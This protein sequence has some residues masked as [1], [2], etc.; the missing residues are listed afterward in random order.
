MHSREGLETEYM[1]TEWMHCIKETVKAA[2]K[3]GMSAWL[4]DEDRFPSGGAGGMVSAAGGDVCRA[5][6][7]TLEISRGGFVNDDRV[8]TV[9]RAVICDELILE[10]KRIKE[11][12]NT[13]L[14]ENEVLLVFRMETS[15]PCEWFNNEAPANNLNPDAVAVFIKTT[16]EAYKSEI[17]E[18]FGKTVP[19]IFTDE[20]NISDGRCNFDIAKAWIPWTDEFEKYF[21]NV[22]GYDLLDVV[23]FIFF[24]AV[25]S[26]KVRHDYW[27]TV[28]E[29]YCEAYSKQIGEWCGKNNLKFTG[30]YHS[31]N[32]LGFGVRTSGAFMPHYRYLHIPGIDMLREQTAEYLTVKQCTSVANQY[33]KKYVISEMYGCTG[34]D[35]TFEGQKWMGDWQYVMGVNIRCQHLALYSLKGCRKRDYPPAFS[36]NTS[37]WKYNNVVEDYFG[38]LTAVL[39]EGKVERDVLVIHPASTAWSMVG[40]YPYEN[41]ESKDR[42]INEANE[43]G[44]RFTNFISLILGFHYDFDLGD[45][46]IL[47]EKGRVEGKKLF[48]N[49]AD[50]SLVI[51]PS[52]KTLLSSTV[53]LLRQ[54]M[55]AGG[56]AVAVAPLATMIDGEVSPEINNLFIHNNMS[57][58]N[59]QEQLCP[60]FEKLLPRRVSIRNK[61][62]TEAP[63][64]LYML[65]DL[66]DCK[67]LFV[68][69]N[70]RNN[71]HEVKITVDGEGSVEEWD[72]L[73]GKVKNIAISPKERKVSFIT[74]FGP[75]GSRLF[76]IHK[77][78]QPVTKEYRFEYKQPDVSRNVFAALGPSCKFTRTMPNA[79]ILDKCSYRVGDTEWSDEMDVWQ[80]QRKVR[81]SLGM[82]QVY[83]NGLPQRYR[84]IDE[85]DKNDGTP[86]AFR[87]L[88]NVK[89]L[90]GKDIYLIAEEV[91]NY[92]INFNNS[93]IKNNSDGWFMDRS[94]DKVKLCGAREGINELVLTCNYL[95]RM[96]FEDCFIIGDF[97]VD[98][99]RNITKEPEILHFGDW[100]LQGYFHYCGSIV[101]HFDF[102]YKA[103]LDNLN[104]RAILELGEYNAVTVEVRV[105]GVGAGHIPW[106]CANSLDIT[107]FLSNG[108]NLIDI[109]VMGSPRNLFGPFH[110]VA[111][112]IPWTTWMS[113][114]REGPDYT[115]GYVVTPYGLMGQVNI[116]KE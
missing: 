38:R 12:N 19:G 111:A 102:E 2:K 3:E 87:F 60:V 32:N 116:Y 108:T 21:L 66:S 4:Y 94:F 84:W 88:F 85:P 72:L 42:G 27:R 55:D 35:F 10:C 29:K 6:G 49:L 115:P 74:S 7:L 8:L 89:S 83:Y 62:A 104:S 93:I 71:S 46:I 91:K 95:N 15:G 70:D 53:K 76:I 96:E 99:E 23:P 67:S 43:I 31:E 105:N 61:Y 109:E 79:L 98:V 63:E 69:N 20:P 77:Y 30:H 26:S 41:M 37:W 22:R 75:A 86:V 113:F 106:R 28:T 56:K 40:C 24:Y 78:K 36:Y 5:K 51:I 1:G 114:R 103:E 45:E 54:F 9:F 110:Q 59:E 48:V 107:R 52:V 34:W 92:H 73:T 58:I 14:N 65:R 47:E 81:D 25:K 57:V 64:F 13:D 82:R 112:N 100:C 18:E 11:T 44:D 68:V 80:A 17:G 50:Y 90:P 33:G 39:S 97:G 16:Y 101:Y